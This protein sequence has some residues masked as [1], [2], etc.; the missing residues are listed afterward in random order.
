MTNE[1]RRDKFIN[2]N[3]KMYPSFLAL[4]W[5]VLF[6][7]TITT[8][9]FTQVKGLTYSEC[10]MFETILTFSACV[11]CIP[12]AKLFS[13]V[14]PIKALRVGLF[15]YA[16]FLILCIVGTNKFVIL[17][18][19]VFLAFGYSVLS[20]KGSPLLTDSLQVVKR[21][22]EYGKIYG[23]GLSIFYC[24]EAFGAVA[25]SFVYD[26]CPNKSLAF[27]ISLACVGLAFVY[28][29]MFKE[30]SKFQQ[31]NVEIDASEEATSTKTK[32]RKRGGYLKLLA[33][34]FV[35]SILIYSFVF[36]GVVSIDTGAF[37]IYLQQ[38]TG[39]GIVPLWA[40]GFFYGAMKLCV[41]LSNRFQFKYNLKFGVR[42]L[43]IFNVLLVATLL[44][45]GILFVVAPFNVVTIIV[46]VVSSCIMCSLRT[47]NFI[48][49]NNYMQVC[50]PPKNLEKLYAMGAVVQYFGYAVFSAIFS[51][52]LGAFNDNYGKSMLVYVAIALPLVIFSTIF[53]LRVL[54]KKYAQKFTIIKPEYTEDDY[55]PTQSK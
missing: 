33:S 53:F 52:L 15:G 38:L 40:F 27:Y 34:V 11:L 30:P 5:D 54:T 44:I 41:A 2:R 1:E 13:K 19:P 48:F 39:K 3:I 47:P 49:I 43:I 14:T 20:V 7:M 25:I 51:G 36:R 6:V 12:V 46:I 8:L 26:L 21:T 50:M 4:V 31:Q 22:R 23:K 45:N 16:A 17:S 35:V 42:S 24:M 37:K 10:M 9:Y 32:K 29:F 55:E 28:S 18:A